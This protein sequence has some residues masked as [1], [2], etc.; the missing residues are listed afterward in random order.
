MDYKWNFKDN[1]Y[2]YQN[3][4]TSIFRVFESYGGEWIWWEVGIHIRNGIESRFINQYG[5]KY[6]T[7]EQAMLNC[8]ANCIPLSVSNAIRSE[9]HLTAES[10]ILF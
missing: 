2:T 4:P 5:G 7:A 6:D 9:V 10:E 1:V 3:N 8:E